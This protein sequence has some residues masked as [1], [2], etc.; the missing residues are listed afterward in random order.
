[1]KPEEI[2]QAARK[3]LF[4]RPACVAD[5]TAQIEVTRDEVVYRYGNEECRES[6]AGE[7]IV[8]ADTGR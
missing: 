1:M 6:R 2:K 4:G 5:Y 7:Q 8:D 3:A